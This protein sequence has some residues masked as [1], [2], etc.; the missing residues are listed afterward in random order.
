MT[1]R[2]S[3]KVSADLLA[4]VQLWTTQPSVQFRLSLL[5]QGEEVAG[6]E[7]KGHAVL[8]AVLLCANPLSA[9]EEALQ[10]SLSRSC[11]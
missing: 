11:E 9:E 8:P 7:G 4:T 10:R 5:D 1:H 6:A 2:Y 3:V